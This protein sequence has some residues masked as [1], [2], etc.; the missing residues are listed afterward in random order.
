MGPLKF[1]SE[2]IG[3]YPYE[4]LANVQSKTRYG[5][6]ENAGCIFYNE[7]TVNGKAEN[8]RLFAHEIAH[9]WFGNSAT[10]E[11]WHHL[12]LSEGFATYLTNLYKEYRYGKDSFIQQ[13][14]V[15]RE[16]VIEYTKKNNAPI[17]DTTIT[18]YIKLLN[19]NSYQ[20]ASWILH[21]L[22]A[23]VGDRKFWKGLTHYYETFKDSTA[24]TSD[25]QKSMEQVYKKGLD[26]F[27]S[28]WLYYSGHP[29]LEIIQ[30]QKNNRITEITIK[31]VQNEKIFH[32]PLEIE[33][34]KGKRKSK[35]VKSLMNSKSISLGIRGT[36]NSFQIKLDPECKLLFEE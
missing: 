15:D 31:Q 21:M 16:N 1:Y 34:L 28:Q 22:R 25:F 10:E 32:F 26:D 24:M 8:E 36:I 12:W 27:F 7:R 13:M 19:T 4:K 3:S 35:K 33:I 6:M 17:I 9:Q 20:K 23:K 5:G 14:K 29:E 11:N 2:K 30:T 18:N